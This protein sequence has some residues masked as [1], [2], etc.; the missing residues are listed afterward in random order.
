M[1]LASVVV[2][3]YNS[4]RTIIELLNS[5]ANQTWPDIELIIADDCSTDRTVSL[6]KKWCKVHRERFTRVVLSVSRHRQGVVYNANRGIKKIQSDY[7]KLI[8]GDDVLLPNCIE[9]NMQFIKEHDYGLVFSKVEVF[10]DGKGLRKAVSN[11][12]AILEKSYQLLRD[13]DQ[14]E[15]LKAMY[16]PSPSIFLTKE[17][18]LRLEGFDTR[19]PNWEDAPFYTKMICKKIPFGFIDEETVRYRLHKSQHNI[20]RGFAIDFIKVYLFVR[21]PALIKFGEIKFAFSQLRGVWKELK[22][23]LSQELQE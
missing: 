17:L 10:G 8:A 4:E 23:L 16:L 20:Y 1:A 2:V 5:I 3:S 22:L 6:A 12:K 14:I 15:M 7:I 19:F 21:I 13:G 11:R 18:F 9:D